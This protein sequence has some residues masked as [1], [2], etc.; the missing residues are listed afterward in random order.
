MLELLQAEVGGV[1]GDA[2]EASAG[3]EERAEGNHEVSRAELGPVVVEQ[4]E[5][6]SRACEG[7]GVVVLAPDAG[8]FFLGPA[9]VLLH[10]SHVDVF[11]VAAGRARRAGFFEAEAGGREPELFLQRLLHLFAPSAAVRLWGFLELLCGFSEARVWAVGS[12]ASLSVAR[13]VDEFFEAG[14]C[15]FVC[16]FHSTILI[17]LQLQKPLHNNMFS[18]D[19]YQRLREQEAAFAK[20]FA[21]HGFQHVKVQGDGNCLYRA[22][23]RLP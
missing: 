21:A 22:V 17:P 16:A 5:P 9:E 20:E 2:V 6:R 13:V 11:L 7:G 19:H 18:K 3:R 23:R 14:V 4:R 1:D 10:H 15:F 12:E 8:R